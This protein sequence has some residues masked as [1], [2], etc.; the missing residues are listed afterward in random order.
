M[1]VLEIVRS[2]T[3]LYWV[4]F[5]LVAE[6]QVDEG[7]NSSSP[8]NAENVSINIV[9]ETPMNFKVYKFK[10]MTSRLPIVLLR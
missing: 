10:Y 1:R 9:T 6:G 7:G 3:G 8:H 4:S 2:T 5:F